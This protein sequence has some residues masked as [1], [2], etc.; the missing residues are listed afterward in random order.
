M[1][2]EMNEEDKEVCSMCGRILD[3]VEIIACFGMCRVCYLLEYGK[4][5][6]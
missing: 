4:E 3:D 2:E 6:Q 5:V 1:N